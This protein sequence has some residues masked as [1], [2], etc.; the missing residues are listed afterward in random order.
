MEEAES[1]KSRLQSAIKAL[2]RV[3][4]I[5]R[6]G[7]AELHLR[8]QMA[9]NILV[10]NERRIWLRTRDGREILERFNRAASK[11]LEASN[12]LIESP[13]DKSTVEKFENAL[14]EVEECAR[15]LDEESR[16]R[17]MVVT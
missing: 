12:S 15:R 8:L 6:E 17:S 11:L 14:L 16:R 5:E 7:L 9:Y 10:Q 3:S 2:G 13:G 1:A 4:T